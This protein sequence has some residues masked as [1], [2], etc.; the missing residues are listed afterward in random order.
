MGKKC[1]CG[2]E[3]E[4]NHKLMGYPAPIE[5]S[6]QA[7]FVYCKIQPQAEDL[8]LISLLQA[9]YISLVFIYCTVLQFYLLTVIPYCTAGNAVTVFS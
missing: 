9:Y 8:K 7:W 4:P 6:M 2:E 1:M 5:K 3:G